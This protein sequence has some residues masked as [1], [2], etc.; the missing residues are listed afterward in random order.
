MSTAPGAEAYFRR[1][2]L[3][4]FTVITLSFGYYTV[5]AARGVMALFRVHPCRRGQ[6]AQAQTRRPRARSRG[7]GDW[8]RE[9]AGA[10]VRPRLSLVQEIQRN[11]LLRL[12]LYGAGTAPHPMTL[13]LKMVVAKSEAC[14][15]ATAYFRTARPL[16]ALVTVLGLAY[17][18]VRRRTGRSSCF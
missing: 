4:W 6:V 11:P 10:L 16:P 13:C 17:F 3:F 1:G 14:K 12:S 8:T 2:S 5:K 15:A 18:A 9:D 7:R